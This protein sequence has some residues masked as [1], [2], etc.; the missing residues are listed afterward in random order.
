[1]AQP[2]SPRKLVVPVT[3]VILAALLTAGHAVAAPSVFV[4]GVVRL[5][6]QTDY[7]GTS[8][9][10]DGAPYTLTNPAGEF[11]LAVEGGRA[12]VLTARH[13]GYLS[14]QI[15][16]E[17]FSR[18]VGIPST[19][20][21]AGDVNDDD[22]IDLADLLIVSTAYGTEPPSDGRAD[23][24]GDGRVDLADLLILAQNYNLRGPLSWQDR[25]PPGQTLEWR[26]RA[27]LPAPRYN[28]GV[29]VVD[30][31]VYAV[32]GSNA[33]GAPVA[34]VAALDP[35]ANTWTR[36]ADMPTPRAGLAV[37][38]LDGKLY[39]IG[40][41]GSSGERLAVVEVYDPAS[42][43]WTRRA[44]MPT[45]RADLAAAASQG[46]VYALGGASA[47]LLKTVEAYDPASDAWTPRADMPTA[48]SYLGA[49]TLQGKIYAVGGSTPQ[50][51]SAVEVYD[52]AA[53]TWVAGPPLLE[54]RFALGVV[55]DG[56]RLFALG[57]WAV[58]PSA[59]GEA[60]DPR[61]GAWVAE[62]PLPQARANLGA[63]AAGDRLYAVGGW[64]SVALAR[65]D[66]GMLPAPATGGQRAPAKLPPQALPRGVKLDH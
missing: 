11:A 22:V 28:L 50:P 5:Q 64:N 40:G 7:S 47:A 38:A 16:F 1:M 27:A 14:R 26:P 21:L 15:S 55:S 54:P 62:P 39:A 4:A 61:T 19:T 13:P 2:R 35:V 66:E 29:A 23:L 63:G 6:A 18:P 9:L 65:V 24:N 3:L 30:G 41:T 48:R 53:D 32:G 31:I 17:A 12:H 58:G 8:I 42:D 56:E 33:D 52:P 49:A 59:Q 60:F 43:T 36:R 51:S 37:T 46:K 25:L 10:L 34:T 44:D 20:L 57:G 45:P